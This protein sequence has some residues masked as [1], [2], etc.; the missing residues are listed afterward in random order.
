V[1]SIQVKSHMKRWFTL[2]L[3][4]LL[5]ACVTQ[6]GAV[7][8]RG[9]AWGAGAFD[10]NGERIYFTS[11]NEEN[12]RITYAGG[13]P[14]GRMMM[15]GTFTCASCHSPDGEGGEHV[16][17]MQTM[18]APN[19]QWSALQAEGEHEGEEGGHEDEH[20]DYG[21]EDFRLAVVEGQ[22]PDGEPL[23]PDMPRWRMNDADLEDLAQF[24]DTLP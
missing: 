21:L 20:G 2:F 23:E 10:S 11:T 22:H 24:L 16:M 3:A 8:R 13:P 18:D 9:T 4:L 12:E 5:T 14:V 1:I 6:S 15:G 17:Q 19:I 7:R